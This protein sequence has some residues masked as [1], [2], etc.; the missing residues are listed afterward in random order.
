MVTYKV[1]KTKDYTV[2]S[3]THL[4]DKNLSF[5]AKGLLSVML[6][7]PDEWDY[8]MNGLVAISKENLTAVRNTLTELED[9]RYLIRERKQNAKG[10]FEYEYH[11]YETP[12][13]ENTVTQTPYTENPYTDNP[14]T[15]NN[16]Q[17]ST[18]E[19]NTNKSITKELNTKYIGEKQKCFSV[20]TLE[21]VK[22]YCQERKNNVDAQRFID[23]YTANGW[24]VGK[25]KMKDWKAAVRTW[26]KNNFTSDNKRYNNETTE[27][28]N[29]KEYIKKNGK[30]YIP[31]GVG[32]QVDPYKED[33][34]PF[35]K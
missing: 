15:D 9:N 35:F 14:Y 21:E 7:L 19:L 13:T 16:I 34:L 24:K 6:S 2:M 27:T 31:N 10:Q 20:P 33:D 32:V 4:R 17:L 29:G 25:N 5:K 26:E 12:H 30:Y 11:I 1:H 28:I 23:Y 8:S 3:N 22:A 18:K